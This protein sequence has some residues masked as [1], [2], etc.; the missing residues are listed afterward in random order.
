MSSYQTA[1]EGN[2]GAPQKKRGILLISLLL[3]GYL[4][5]RCNYLDTVPR[6][7][8][9][10]YWGALMQ[11][12]HST[13]TVASLSDF[14]SMVLKEWNAF[15][16]PSMGYYSLLVA[17][18]LID[19][20]NQ[21]IINFTN[22]L[23]AMFSIFCVYKILL[24]FF[25][26]KRYHPE[27]LLATAAYAFEPLF[28]G[29]SIYLNTDFPVLVFYTAALAAL[30]Y[31]RYG[32]FAIASIFMVFS[33]EP[34]I[35]LWAT[36]VGGLGLYVLG[37]VFGELWSG[38]IPTKLGEIVPRSHYI[39][40]QPLK[41]WP[42]LY[43]IACLLLPVIA[44]KLF[45]IARRG[46]MWSDDTGLKFDSNGWNCFGFNTRVMLNRA[47]EMF[48]LDFHWIPAILAL[49]LVFIGIGRSVERKRTNKLNAANAV[50]NVHATEK[51]STS[52]ASHWWG[53]LPIMFSFLAFVAFNLSYI[54]FI[55][56]RYVVPSGFFLIMC[57]V[58]AM[59]FAIKS[60]ALRISILSIM[61][62][63]FFAQT[64]RTIDPLS[65][66]AFGTA[67]F[68]KHEIL[69]I[70]SAGEAVGNGFVYN[71]EFTAVD[72]LFNLMNKAMP[73]KP[74]TVLIAWNADGWYPWFFNGGVFVDPVKLVRTVDWRNTFHYNVI[75]LHELQTT[76]E[77]QPPAS[78]YYVYMPWLSKFSDE[79]AEL[80]R[81]RTIYQISEPTE[82]GYQG[83]NLRFYP[84]RRLY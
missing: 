64:F 11:S 52:Q 46:A 13:K 31:G 21:Y 60:R 53:I 73:I 14:P 83:Y 34:G 56:P 18:Q 43:R 39:N 67:P 29:C 79:Q 59:H 72:K 55:I 12:V 27:V 77:T 17:G 19:F 82:V 71:S 81:L 66:L 25:P 80:A 69:Q 65:K 32:L 26:E 62:V 61:F 37:Y 5:I 58:F 54:T 42:S 74:D 23:L 10:S 57:A 9:A 38:R 1:P 78:A 24:F 44:F 40:G 68:S 70:D 50:V 15:G 36:L 22:I 49:V 4:I 63:L 45:T 20:P 84:L 28:F 2:L 75:G 3:L 48:V 8:A 6:W 16:H 51:T 47:G 76:P 41:L 35:F 7:D 30:L 33:K